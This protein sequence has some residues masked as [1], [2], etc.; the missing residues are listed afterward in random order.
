MEL[1]PER[2]AQI[3][4]LFHDALALPA[5]ERPAFLEQQC[6]DAALRTEVL[7][8]LDAHAE[9]API[10]EKKTETLATDLAEAAEISHHQ[11]IGPYR[12]LRLLGQGGMG[13][14]YLAQ[15]E[16][17]N[18]AVAL[19]V[20]RDVFAAPQHLAR[21]RAEHRLLARLNHPGI[22]R[23]LHAG[24]TDQG[25]P[26]FAMEYV[27]GRPIT[28]YC[29]E[30]RL[31]VQ[32]R[33]ALFVEVCAAV[34]DAHRNLI[35][36]R[37]LKPSNILVTEAGEVKLLD[38]GIAKLLAHESSEAAAKTTGALM[39]P[40]YAAPEQ[41]RG[42]DAILATDVYALGVLLHE[43][44]TGH[45]PYAHGDRLPHEVSEAVL[46]AEPRKPSTQTLEPAAVAKR[47]G[48]QAHLRRQLQG[49]L[50]TICLKALHKDA[51]ARY[52]SAGELRADLERYLQGLPVL[53]QPRT[54]Q[55][56]LRKFVSR[57]RVA[58]TVASLVVLAFLATVGFYTAQ[59][60]QQRN[61]ARL[62]AQKAQQVSDY[63]VRLFE[64]SDPYTAIPA[65]SQRVETL[66]QQGV[67]R[68]DELADQPDV[69]AQMLRV[70]GDVY[71]QRSQYDR[72]ELL[73][74]QAVV[75]HREHESADLEMGE[76]LAS[77]GVW[78]YY[79]DALDSAA[80]L[81]NDAIGFF[82]RH[83]PEAAASLADALNH[84]GVV[85]RQQGDYEA[86]IAH[87][88]R[89]V[90]LRKALHPEPHRDVAESLNNLAVSLYQ[91]GDYAAAEPYYAEALQVD[92][93]VFGP[94]HPNVANVLANLGK[95]Y[96]LQGDYVRAESLLV[97]AIQIRRDRLPA[98]HYDV[99]VGL[100]QLA[101]LMLHEEAY[102]RAAAYAEESLAIREALFGPQ[103]SRVATA[104]STLAIISKTQGD[105]A[106]AEA[107]TQRTL[108][109]YIANLGPRHHFSGIMYCN[110]GDL[111]Y[112]QQRYA[113]AEAAYQEGLSILA[114][115]LPADHWQLAFNRS[116]FAQVWMA[117]H[118][119]AEAEPLLMEGYTVLNNQFGASHARS[120][121]ALDRVI[122]L[123]EAWGKPAAAEAYRALRIL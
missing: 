74:R 88:R 26:Y 12:I 15:H 87:H 4:A 106:R 40:A 18:A 81:L 58:V 85:V 75:L 46:H 76:S 118:R 55:Y 10:F 112:L 104:L 50:D 45:H 113:E 28:D 44:L 24:V 79:T 89:A 80:V 90:A 68:V 110:L 11:H 119:F 57:N 2:W 94:Q 65:D 60:T 32:A 99:A 29:D 100:N 105:Y 7:L 1:T 47:G 54:V 25:V 59:L 71:V 114:E 53:A 95:L 9:P 38:F 77:L 22:A 66:L 61:R 122:Q 117:Q 109:I 37:D 36:H 30:Q 83:Q 16:E 31:S 108:D 6:D 39:T 101:Q 98:P 13:S 64:A 52:A 34:Y 111:Y 27:E 103:H 23:I 5:D 43:L 97:A 121:E 49:D 92:Q 3:E 20:V 73:L 86:A 84:L 19:K 17:M 48:T 33:V 96:E 123:Y 8:L 56:H 107:Q 63:L 78:F 120:R 62:E 41:V 70:L 69:Q 51:H 91:Q 42:E 102:D 35:V 82:E 93:A 115:V 21:F 72:A 14:V 116:L 67:A